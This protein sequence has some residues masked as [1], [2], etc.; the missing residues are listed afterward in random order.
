ML[1]RE[2][3]LILM[4]ENYKLHSSLISWMVH[5]L[6]RGGTEAPSDSWDNEFHLLSHEVIFSNFY[7]VIYIN[8]K[9]L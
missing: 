9:R 3:V 6:V 1:F 2:L 7:T 5:L 4:T 8:K